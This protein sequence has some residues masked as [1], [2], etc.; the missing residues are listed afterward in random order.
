MKDRQHLDDVFLATVIRL[1]YAEHGLQDAH[2]IVLLDGYSDSWVSFS[3]VLPE[4]A[5]N[6]RVLELDQR[7][8]GD[9]EPGADALEGASAPHCRRNAVSF[10]PC[11]YSLAAVA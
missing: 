4:L 6:Y 1:H 9:S 5:A 10:V 2:P 8:H 11:R 7:G 3:T